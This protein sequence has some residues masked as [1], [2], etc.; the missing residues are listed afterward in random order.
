MQPL[1]N[2]PL[3]SSCKIHHYVA[4]LFELE[5][6]PSLALAVKIKDKEFIEGKSAR[7]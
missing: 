5:D 1:Q 3:C 7:Y 2:P 4:A 6:P